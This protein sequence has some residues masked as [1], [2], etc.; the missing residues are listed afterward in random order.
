M[1]LRISDDG[2]GISDEN[3]ERLFEPFVKLDR[4]RGH[5]M[6]YGIGLNL[7]QRIVQLH[8]GTIRLLPR[9]PRGTEAVVTI[10]RRPSGASS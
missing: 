5:R 6:G 9:E 1:I 4:A 2:I 10:S 7:C 3:S 8:G